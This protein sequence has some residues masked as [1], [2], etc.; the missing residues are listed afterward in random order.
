MR[1]QVYKLGAEYGSA[2]LSGTAE[3][4][5]GGLLGSTVVTEPRSLAAVSRCYRAETGGGGRLEGGL[6][7]VHQFTKVGASLLAEMSSCSLQVEMFLV[8]AGRL[9]DSEA[10]LERVL[11]VQVS[12][13]L[14]ADL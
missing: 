7:R 12:I 9:E 2:A 5:I 13:A 4:A 6:Y 10:A 1:L 3:M 14:L 11:G 8:T